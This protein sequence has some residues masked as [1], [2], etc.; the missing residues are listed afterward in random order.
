MKTIN[1]TDIQYSQ[2][3]EYANIN[4][5]NLTEALTQLL[6]LGNIKKYNDETLEAMEEVEAIIR[7]EKKAKIYNNI[8]E[9]WEDLEKDEAINV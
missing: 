8:A 3:L 5:F 6:K 2:L 4:N 1:L 7:G 9:V